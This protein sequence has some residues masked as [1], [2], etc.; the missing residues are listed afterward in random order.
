MKRA[1]PFAVAAG[2]AV[3]AGP[4]FAQNLGDPVLGTPPHALG[5]PAPASASNPVAVNHAGSM[6]GYD[7]D[8]AE[9]RDATAALNLL[10][11]R[12]YAAFSNFAAEGNGFRATVVN[13]GQTSQVSIDP[14]TG[15]VGGA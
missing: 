7:P 14:R 6:K 13:G 12:G 5:S 1:L 11:A 8:N 9:A 4:A 3:A 15:R 10:E 2:L